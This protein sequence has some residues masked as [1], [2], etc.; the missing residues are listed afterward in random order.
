M[1]AAWAVLLGLC[2]LGGCATQQATF[3]RPD[4]HP[5]DQNQLALD[6]AACNGEAM[7][8]NMAAGNN[9]AELTNVFGYSA[10]MQTVF[11]G[12]MANRGYL[13]RQ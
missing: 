5:I 10:E 9:A 11:N 8:A 1:R 6:R 13:V 12:C 7:K 3:Y 2:A 4:G